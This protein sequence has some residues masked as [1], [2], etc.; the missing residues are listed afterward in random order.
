MQKEVSKLKSE[1]EKLVNVCGNFR[2]QINR[3]EN[4]NK[5]LEENNYEDG[6]DSNNNNDIINENSYNNRHINE[7]NEIINNL[8]S[9]SYFI[10]NKDNDNFTFN[11]NDDKTSTY[12]SITNKPKV[13]NKISKDVRTSVERINSL[14]GKRVNL[15]DSPIRNSV[16]DNRNLY[17]SNINNV[18]V[19][20]SFNNKITNRNNN[21]NY[22]KPVM[23]LNDNHG[24]DND[25]NIDTGIA[26]D[27]ILEDKINNELKDD[28]PTHPE[29]M[30][31]YFTGNQTLNP[32]NNTSKEEK[33]NKSS[34]EI[35]KQLSTKENKINNTNNNTNIANID[36]KS[37]S[38]YLKSK[39]LKRSKQ[40]K[41]ININI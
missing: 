36:E 28:Y 17:A 5:E 29:P 20:A 22:N 32:I 37:P 25:N 38:H 35:I 8:K 1:K 4:I 40:P 34:L 10:L 12:K 26:V 9:E 21:N 31:N 11:N 19:S 14:K 39:L 23:D 18:S 13:L 7:R 24:I 27:R 33:V 41:N 16:G 2:T 6:Y 30:S 3:L 15:D